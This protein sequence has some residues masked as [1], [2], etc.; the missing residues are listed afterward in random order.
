MHPAIIGWFCF[1][2]VYWIFEGVFPSDER[3]KSIIPSAS[4]EKTVA[5]N[6]LLSLPY[7]IVFW[8]LMPD[9]SN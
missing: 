3:S 8:E 4:V 2:M 9:I 1:W 7:G 6:M 5:R